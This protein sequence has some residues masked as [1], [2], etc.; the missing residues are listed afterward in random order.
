MIMNKENIRQVQFGEIA[1]KI[2]WDYIDGDM[3]FYKRFQDMPIKHDGSAQIDMLLLAVCH[4]GKMEVEINS[5]SHTLVANDI[6]IAL[7]N[8]RLDNYMLSPD[9]EGSVLCLSHRIIMESVSASDLWN[10]AY[11]L[12]ENPVLHANEAGRDMFE[13]Y[14]NIF[15]LKIEQENTLFRKEIFSSLIRAVIYDILSIIGED[16]PSTGNL[17]IKSREMLFKRFIELLS[18]SRIKPRKVT[19]YAE[20]LCVSPKYLSAVS[21]QVSGK[22]AFDWIGEYVSM[23]IRHLLKNSDKSIKEITDTLDF[24][25]MSFFGKYCRQHFGLSPMDLRRKLREQNDDADAPEENA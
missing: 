8:D 10:R 23:D 4:K 25:N 12:R 13:S 14:A 15:R 17:L 21:K 1:D 18:G 22:T 19:W 7:P 6:I 9:F 11:R 2:D 16:T 3:A 5:I 24:P 20:Q